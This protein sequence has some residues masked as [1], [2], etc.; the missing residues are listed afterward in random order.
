MTSDLTAL[1]DSW[2]LSLLAERKSANTIA[3][4]LK[5]LRLFI[6][7]EREHD[8]PTAVGDIERRH[9]EAWIVH[10]SNTRKSAT[11][12][13]RY[14]SLQQ[15]WRW[16]VDEDEVESGRSS[17]RAQRGSSSTRSRSPTLAT[18]GGYA[19]RSDSPG[20]QFTPVEQSILNRYRRRTWP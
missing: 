20:L 11:A 3:S 9:V 16:A 18:D 13:V 4:Y 2:E 17:S 5:S 14:R 7:F 6:E 8:A 10:L 15:F 1:V 12:A 19:W